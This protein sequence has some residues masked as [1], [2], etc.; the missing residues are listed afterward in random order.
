MNRYTVEQSSLTADRRSRKHPMRLL[1]AC[2]L[3][4]RYA[5]VSAWTKH[6]GTNCYDGHG[7]VPSFTGDKPFANMTVKEC[8]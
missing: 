8:G 6:Q 2:A 7:G 3:A 4:M 1:L 5:A